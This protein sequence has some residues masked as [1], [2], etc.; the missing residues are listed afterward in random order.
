MTEMT[1]DGMPEPPPRWVSPDEGVRMSAQELDWM[2]AAALPHVGT[3]DEIPNLMAVLVHCQ[4]GLLRVTATDRYSLY[5]EQRQVQQT[6]PTWTF[7][8]R[9]TDVKLL[10]A[11]LANLLRGMKEKDRLREPCDLLV[12][13]QDGAALLGVVGDDLDVRFTQAEHIVLPDYEQLVS[14]TIDKLSAGVGQ[15]DLHLNPTLLARCKA[16]QTAGRNT[17]LFRFCSGKAKQSPV[18][19]ATT[20]ED[21]DALLLIMPINGEGEPATEDTRT[22]A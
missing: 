6:C 18:V 21:D 12:E 13:E 8:L 10:R 20:D 17:A 5:R 16:M 15:H 1:L 14:D 4:D 11:L 22:A 19:V 2:L 9:A 3:D 7:L